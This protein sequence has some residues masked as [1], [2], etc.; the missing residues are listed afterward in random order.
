[1]QQQITIAA[2]LLSITPHNT[3]ASCAGAFAEQTPLLPPTIRRAALSDAPARTAFLFAL[4]NAHHVAQ[5]V[6]KIVAQR[7]LRG[8]H[9]PRRDFRARF[10]ART[11]RA[12]PRH[13]CLLR[14]AR[15]QTARNISGLLLIIHNISHRVRQLP[16]APPSG[17]SSPARLPRA[18]SSTSATSRAARPLPP[19][20]CA[21]ADHLQHQ[22]LAHLVIHNTLHRVRHLPGGLESPGCLR[23]PGPLGRPCRGGSTR[24]HPKLT[25]SQASEPPTSALCHDNPT[26][27]PCVTSSR[28]HRLLLL[29]V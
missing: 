11:P 4:L 10:R 26:P 27:L 24:K 25:A 5:H 3:P 8:D 16:A 22:R 28:V 23:R 6:V 20:T 12:T 13:L 14:P 17:P 15:Q 7:H 18:I 29:C 19:T 21:P 9:L 2:T 1:M